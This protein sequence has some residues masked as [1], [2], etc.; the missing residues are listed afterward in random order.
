KFWMDN[1]VQPTYTNPINPI[2]NIRSIQP[3]RQGT[4]GWTHTFSPTLVNQFNP[5]FNFYRADMGPSA[6]A[7][8]IFPVV[9]SSPFFTFLGAGGSQG[10]DVT[11]WQLNDN[12]SW[13]RGTH[14]FRFGDNLRRVL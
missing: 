6:Q 14:T 7:M 11:Q 5:G 4:A 13:T 3:E 9:L 2:F 8:K 10:R 12:L 1:G